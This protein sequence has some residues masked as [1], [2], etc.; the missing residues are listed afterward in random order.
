MPLRQQL[1]DFIVKAEELHK[2]DDGTPLYKY[3]LT[4]EQHKD[5]IK[6]VNYKIPIECIKCEKIFKKTKSAH[7]NNK[8]GC[9]ICAKKKSAAKLKLGLTKFIE[10]V[11]SIEKHKNADG[12][13]KYDYSH[14]EEKDYKNTSTELPIYCYKCESRMPKWVD[15]HNCPNF[16]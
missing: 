11:M 13:H 16:D 2:N 7:L 9:P 4:E 5:Y 1:S 3:N 6:N 15:P 10:K 8:E 12:S 14:L